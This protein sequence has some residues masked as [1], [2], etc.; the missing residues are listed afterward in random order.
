M[1]RIH[2]HLV[3]Y[4]Q[5]GTLDLAKALIEEYE[6]SY[7]KLKVMKKETKEAIQRKFEEAKEQEITYRE[8]SRKIKDLASIYEVTIIPP[9]THNPPIPSPQ[10][11]H[12]SQQ[13]ELARKR[14]EL[15]GEI[16]L[17]LYDKNNSK[18]KVNAGFEA[19]NKA[20]RDAERVNAKIFS[21]KKEWEK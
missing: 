15:K 7:K 21:H 17:L 8:I 16:E 10:K 1:S 4:I 6:D 14:V 3:E 9:T 13:K 12:S 18:I 19:L 2:E 11:Q 5:F 20:K